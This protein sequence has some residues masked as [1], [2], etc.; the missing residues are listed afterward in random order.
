MPTPTNPTMKTS[1]S[2]SRTGDL[3]SLAD[4]RAFM[5]KVDASGIPDSAVVRANVWS[6]QRD[7]TQGWSISAEHSA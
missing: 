3:M 4:L 7:H 5:A 2:S 6:D 1:V